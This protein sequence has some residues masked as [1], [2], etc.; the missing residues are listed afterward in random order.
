MLTLMFYQN[1]SGVWVGDLTRDESRL[2]A[3]THPA[4]IAAA[5]FAMDEY[6]VRVETEQGRFEMEFPVNT[7]ELDALGQ[8]MLD[9]DMGKWMSGFCT[10][11]RFDFANPDPMDTR[12]DIHLRTAIHHLPP[13][14]VKVRPTKPEPKSFKKALKNQNK[15]VYYPWC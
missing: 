8:L 7:G 2:L 9:Q 4:T 11:S 6:S 14:L 10:F 15:Y 5:I 3:T 12:A 1:C 13:E